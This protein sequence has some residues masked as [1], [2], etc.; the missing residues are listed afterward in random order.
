MA[1][2]IECQHCDLEVVGSIPNCLILKNFQKMAL[3]ALSLG[4]A[5]K[6]R[7][8]NHNWSAQCQYNMIVEYHVLFL[9]CD[10]TVREHYKRQH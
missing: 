7:A 5:L 9:G 10:T 4:S 2:L 1:Q 3:V 8:K 6:N